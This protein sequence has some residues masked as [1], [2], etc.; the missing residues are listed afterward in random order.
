[1]A[2]ATS[3]FNSDVESPSNIFTS[4]EMQEGN[5]SRVNV[6]FSSLLL[7]EIFLMALATSIFNS[8]VESPANIFTSTEMQ[9][10]HCSRINDIFST[11]LHD[12]FEMA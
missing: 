9:E 6:I 10:G 1:M 5:C 7:P 12:K 11:L 3:V 4:T 8:D 2:L